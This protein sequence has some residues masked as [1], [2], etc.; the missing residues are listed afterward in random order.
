MFLGEQPDQ[1]L[2]DP[3]LAEELVRDHDQ[4][5][6]ATLLPVDLDAVGKPCRRH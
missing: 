4:R 2:E 6:F 5:A 1:A 3:G